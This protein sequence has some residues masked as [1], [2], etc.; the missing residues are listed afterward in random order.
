[1]L[2]PIRI[3]V[4]SAL[5]LYTSSSAWKHT[6]FSILVGLLVYGLMLRWDR[7]AKA[8]GADSRQLLKPLIICILMLW[9]VGY[10]VA[11]LLHSGHDLVEGGYALLGWSACLFAALGIVAG[12]VHISQYVNRHWMAPPR[13]K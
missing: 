6:S 11:S 13:V 12:S 10:I 2:P 5:M 4:L 8:Q 7:Y 9:G 3:D 1:M